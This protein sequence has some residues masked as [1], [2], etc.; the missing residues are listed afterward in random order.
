MKRKWLDGGNQ[1]RVK[2]INCRWIIEMRSRVFS[3]R[4][5]SIIH[6]YATRTWECWYIFMVNHKG[7]DLISHS[8]REKEIISYSLCKGIITEI[9]Y[10]VA[11]TLYRRIRW[12][13]CCVLRRRRR[14][15]GFLFFLFLSTTRR[16]AS[17]FTNAKCAD[18]TPSADGAS[19]IGVKGEAEQTARMYISYI[20]HACCRCIGLQATSQQSRCVLRA[21]LYIPAEQQ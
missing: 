14:R 12:W 20:L 17:D 7:N 15:R 16:R 3:A 9:V 10:T 21:H 5:W 8:L 13:C 18:S 1:E 2:L 4:P 11:N 6:A 19:R